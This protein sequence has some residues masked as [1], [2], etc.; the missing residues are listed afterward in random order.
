MAVL[1]GNSVF[2]INFPKIKNL[3][4]YVDTMYTNSTEGEE[5]SLSLLINKTTSILDVLSIR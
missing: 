4:K 2:V 3:R 1:K 5:S